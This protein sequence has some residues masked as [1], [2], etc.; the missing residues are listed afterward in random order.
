MKDSYP[1]LFGE[2]T[3]RR[4]VSVWQH[5][6]EVDFQPEKLVDEIESFQKA[7]PSDIIKIPLHGRYPVVD[8]GC[9]IEKGSNEKGKSGSSSCKECIVNSL[10]DY[11]KIQWV[12][13]TDGHYADQLR[14]VKLLKNKFP[15]TPLML[16]VFSPTMVMRKL[17]GKRFT[18]DFLENREA[19]MDA[20]KIVE[21]VT[22]QFMN[23]GV[24]AGASGI[25]MATQEAERINGISDE[26]LKEAL[27]LNRKFAKASK[28]E[29][30]V[31]HVHGDNVLFKEAVDI[32]N[33]DSVNWH[34]NSWP[35]IGE[36]HELFK[37]GLLAGLDPDALL[38]GTSPNVDMLRNY[39]NEYPFILAPS[40]VI[41]Q[42]TPVETLA[43]IVGKYKQE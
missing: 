3:G 33:P 30:N 8:F 34:Y 35:S 28:G 22:I 43:A 38:A 41:L 2:T 1:E 25:F 4:L 37:G 20:Y 5:F 27:E 42:G 13:P 9:S 29:F 7:V 21:D 12:D 23:A 19:V 36:A 40:C 11:E 18:K 6:P 16:T 26:Q 14:I 15:D 10:E 24:E 31:L 39:A 32:F 17:T